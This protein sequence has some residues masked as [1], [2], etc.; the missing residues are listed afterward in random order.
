MFICSL[1][2]YAN[3]PERLRQAGLSFE[4]DLGAVHAQ[5]AADAGVAGELADA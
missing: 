2:T 1:G 5:A 3:D 4:E